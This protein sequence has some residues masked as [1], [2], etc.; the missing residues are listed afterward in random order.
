[1]NLINFYPT[2]IFHIFSG[3]NVQLRASDF[4]G[5]NVRIL[6]LS[7]LTPLLSEENCQIQ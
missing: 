7:R 3:I 2:G 1:M 5:G 6:L 4:D